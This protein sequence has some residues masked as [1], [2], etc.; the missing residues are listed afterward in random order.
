MSMP[1][2]LGVTGLASLL[3]APRG[4]ILEFTNP[5]PERSP[6]LTLSPTGTS[7]HAAACVRQ[8]RPAA[9]PSWP[10]T[11]TP[12]QPSCTADTSPRATASGSRPSPKAPTWTTSVSLCMASRLVLPALGPA[13]SALPFQ[14]TP[15]GDQVSLVGKKRDCPQQ[16]SVSKRVKE[17]GKVKGTGA[18]GLP[19]PLPAHGSLTWCLPLVPQASC[20]TESCRMP[21]HPRKSWTGS[22]PAILV[23]P[24]CPA[25][26]TPWECLHSSSWFGAKT[27]KKEGIHICCA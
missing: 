24:Y 17:K 14:I 6:P 22:A 1:S 3:G 27:T 26:L 10:A 9:H 16:P 2:N 25:P 7:T 23:S 18:D 20:G 11:A 19:P 5:S 15:R 13:S 12:G 4:P 21:T 8:C